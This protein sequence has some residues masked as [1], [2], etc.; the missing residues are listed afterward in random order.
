MDLSLTDAATLLGRSPRQLRYLIQQGKLVARK[1]GGRWVVASSNLPM[2]GAQRQAVAARASE[3]RVATETSL[4]L[5]QPIAAEVS[6][7]STRP[8]SSLLDLRAFREGAPLYRRLRATH[9]ADDPA[10]IHLG[11]SLEHLAQGCHGGRQTARVTAYGEARREAAAAL[12]ALAVGGAEDDPAR[13][14]FLEALEQGY[15]S[16]VAELI[17]GA[18]Q[19]ALPATFGRV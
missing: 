15:L 13:A 12:V 18:E 1:S 16:S 9:G 3:L 5:E 19:P 8:A 14:S 7:P 6:E 2:T 17:R 11:R 4:V 10:T